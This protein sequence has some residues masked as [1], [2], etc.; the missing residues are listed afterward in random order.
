MR[1]TGRANPG[2]KEESIPPVLAGEGQWAVGGA[3]VSALQRFM[4]FLGFSETS[5][6]EDIFSGEPDGAETTTRRR[7]QLFSLPAQRQLE[8]VVLQPK[9]FDDARAA[10]DYLKMRR[11]AVVNLRGTNAD[12]ARRVL[13]FTGGGT[14]ALGGHM[15]RAGEGIFLFWLDTVQISAD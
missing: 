6:D 3:P 12:L 13:D 9:T 7:G 10:A 5:E 11:P 4:T 1:D 14:Y 2:R 8:I 15:L